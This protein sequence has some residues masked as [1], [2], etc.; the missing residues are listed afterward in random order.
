MRLASVA[1]GLV[2]PGRSV[3]KQ[4]P[5]LHLLLSDSRLHFRLLSVSR[6]PRLGG[7]WAV[8]VVTCISRLFWGE[9]KRGL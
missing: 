9:M 7:A 1:N 4:G 8:L 2:S 3:E 5:V 6:A